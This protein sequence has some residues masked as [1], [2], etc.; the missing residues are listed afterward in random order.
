LK[1]NL[2]HWGININPVK[3]DYD[4]PRRILD[5]IDSPLLAEEVAE[6]FQFIQSVSRQKDQQFERLCQTGQEFWK[7]E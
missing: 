5:Q 2:R 1:A 4:H 3:T 6:K 7:I